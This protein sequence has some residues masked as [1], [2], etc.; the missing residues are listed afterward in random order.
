[1][2]ETLDRDKII[3]ISSNTKREENIIALAEEISGKRTGTVHYALTPIFS[4]VEGKNKKKPDEFYYKPSILSQN[5][6]FPEKKREAQIDFSNEFSKLWNEFVIE[7]KSIKAKDP[8][9]YIKQLY[10]VLKKYTSYV[11]SYSDKSSV[12]FF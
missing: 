7:V 4:I 3:E 12:S 1:L 2:P 5:P 8:E 9:I 10:Y 6:P 11:P